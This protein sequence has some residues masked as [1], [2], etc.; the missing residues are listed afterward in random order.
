MFSISRAVS[1]WI[2]R[3]SFVLIEDTYNDRTTNETNKALTFD[4]L[5]TYTGQGHLPGDP[6]TPVDVAVQLITKE[7][8]RSLNAYLTTSPVESEL[9]YLMRSDRA[10]APSNPLSLFSVLT[11]DVWILLLSELVLFAAMLMLFRARND[12]DSAQSKPKHHVANR[13]RTSLRDS[14]FDLVSL[15]FG[16]MDG[17]RVPKDSSSLL[18]ILTFKTLL[19]GTPLLIGAMLTAQYFDNGVKIVKTQEL[20]N[21]NS[22]V[23]I[24]SRL[25]VPAG[26]SF[27]THIQQFAAN[28]LD[29]QRYDQAERSEDCL[30]GVLN[31]TSPSRSAILS[32]KGRASS[33]TVSTGT[34]N[35]TPYDS[36][37]ADYELNANGKCSKLVKVGVPVTPQE[38]TWAVSQHKVALGQVLSN[39]ILL[40]KENGSFDAIVKEHI[41]ENTC[42]RQESQVSCRDLFGLY[43]L[44]GGGLG[45]AMSLKCWR[46]CQKKSRPSAAGGSHSS[47]APGT[48]TAPPA[49]G[50]SSGDSLLLQARVHAAAEEAVIRERMATAVRADKDF[51]LVLYSDFRR[52][53]AGEADDYTVPWNF[54]SVSR[55]PRARRHSNSQDL[56]LGGSSQDT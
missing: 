37:F 20:C 26:T 3:R 19:Y 15:L 50:T 29:H 39:A 28:C 14:L 17:D 52:L 33:N 8:M 56:A 38:S 35:V 51:Q 34:W 45:F 16:E 54:N 25:C 12:A 42:K 10:R 44:L 1:A 7:G 47:A 13:K 40:A 36:K 24:D 31:G 2:A 48:S 55:S 41:Y 9:V 6:S 53:N 49:S 43:I 5:V 27:E 32:E 23:K 46:C 21:A 4:K 11:Y 18:I 30:Q 22:L